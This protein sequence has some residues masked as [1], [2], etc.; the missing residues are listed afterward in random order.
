MPRTPRRGCAGAW[1]PF[2]TPHCEQICEVGPIRPRG[3]SGVR[4]SGQAVG[5]PRKVLSAQIA[6]TSTAIEMTAQS[7]A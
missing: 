6:E 7:G 3:A 1:G 4:S 5:E 2:L